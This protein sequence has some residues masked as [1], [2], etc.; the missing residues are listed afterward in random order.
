[1]RVL[2]I[3]PGSQFMGLGCV[4]RDGNQ[5]KFVG[6]ELVKVKPSKDDSISVRMQRVY[7][8]VHNAIQIWQPDSVAIESV[9]VSKN[10]MSALKL[11]QARGV[12]IA[13]AAM[14]GRSVFEYSPK[15]VKQNVTGSGSASK[16]QV[17][18]MVRLLLGPSLS[19]DALRHD[20]TDA[21]AVSICHAQHRQSNDKFFSL[22]R[23]HDR[24]TKRKPG[25]PRTR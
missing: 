14:C 23:E 25:S 12:A 18:H 9:F 1:M 10:A 22:G 13:A 20:V 11:G 6:H 2:G 7:A 16:E 8:A 5:I 4:D 3:D 24:S 17:E 21:L 15:E 19:S